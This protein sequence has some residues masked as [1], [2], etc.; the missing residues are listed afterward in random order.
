MPG[1][2]FYYNLSSFL[3]ETL[4]EPK[5]R[6]LATIKVKK[7][8][9]N[10]LLLVNESLRSDHLNIYGYKRKTSPNISQ[11]FK[12]ALVY[13]KC[14]SPTAVTHIALQSI[15]TGYYP[16][17]QS[18]SAPTLWQYASQLSLQTFYFGSQVLSWSGGLDRF[19]LEYQYVHKT[20]SPITSDSAVGHDDQIT[21]NAFKNY[22]KDKKSKPF[23]GVIHFN[24]THFPYLEHKKS[25]IY[26]P[27]TY[28]A[29]IG[30]KESIINA[31]DN[32][33][34]NLDNSIGQ[35]MELLEQNNLSEN[36]I[37]I[38]L[39]DHAEAFG[40]HQSF[41][42]TSIMYNEAINVPLLI[43]LP[44][45]MQEHIGKEKFNILKSYQNEYIS[46][47]DIMPTI[48]DIYGVLN[49]NKM[50]GISLLNKKNR[51]YIFATT[52]TQDTTFTYIN[53]INK[54]KYLFDNRSQE[55]Y[56][57]NLDTDPNEN[58]FTTIPLDKIQNRVRGMKYI[59]AKESKK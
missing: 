11:Y 50:N 59:E 27:A 31:Y 43:L 47:I 34:L 24:A 1:I 16:N 4:P 25:D 33:I 18:F 14:F 17:H 41:F 44:K 51:K 42:H 48:L 19:F 38:L 3:N 9:F 45:K 53:T 6:N 58:N 28:T 56:F 49:S 20:F 12:N 37:V 13:Q 26:F 35:V 54:N 15:F 46:N 55:L 23:F 2:S 22:M 52:D 30:K 36:T 40:E 29:G 32:S 39:S 21:I 5:V 57:T 7:I 8:D 10:V